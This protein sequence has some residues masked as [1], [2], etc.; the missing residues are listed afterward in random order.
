MHDNDDL[1]NDSAMLSSDM[2][3]AYIKLYSRKSSFKPARF[4]EYSDYAKSL[5]G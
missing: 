2:S 5:H 4:G 1:D 3:A